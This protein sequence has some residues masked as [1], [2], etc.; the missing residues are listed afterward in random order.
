MRPADA[1]GVFLGPL[2]TIILIFIECARKYSSDTRQK[3]FFCGVLSA[4]F[5]FMLTDWLFSLLPNPAKLIWP[6]ITAIL[7]YAYFSIVKKETRIDSLTGLL[8]RYSFNEFTNSLSRHKTGETW[9]IAMLDLDH[10]KKINGTYGHLEGDNALRMAASAIKNCARKSDFAARYGGDEFALAARVEN[11]IE[12][13]IK[14]IKESLAKYNEKSQ[15]PY[16]VDISYSFDMYTTDGS[17]PIEEFL[18]HL[19]DLIYKQRRLNRRMGDIHG[20]EE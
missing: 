4:A 5:F 19:D 14:K 18:N 17:K 16:K 1:L 6:C 20:G 8:N 10:I 2:L 9:I 3:Y 13:V 7:L 11:G 15:K 12:E